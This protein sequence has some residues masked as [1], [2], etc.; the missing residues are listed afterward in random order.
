MNTAIDRFA[1]AL[2]DELQYEPVMSRSGK[3]FEV[4]GTLIR[5]CGLDAKVGELCE[6]RDARGRTMQRAEVVGFSRDAAILSPFGGLV[7]VG[8][9]TQVFG[10]GKPL[11]VKVG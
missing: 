8:E 4:V 7:G 9:A 3:V 1:E 10:T 6:L 2:E 5:A 11:S